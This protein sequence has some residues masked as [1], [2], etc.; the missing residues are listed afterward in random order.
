[1]YSLSTYN[2]NRFYEAAKLKVDPMSDKYPSM[3]PYVY[4]SNNPIRRIDPNGMLDG[5]FFDWYGKYLGTDGNKK[6][7]KVFIVSDNK[8]RQQIKGNER[9]G[10]T[11]DASKVKADV[12]TTKEV[13]NETLNVYGRTVKNGGDDEE[14]STFDKNGKLK[15][16]PTGNKN[17]SAIDESGD[18]SIH[19]HP[20]N[21][22]ENGNLYTTEEGEDDPEAFSGYNLNI[23]VGDS[24]CDPEGVGCN[25]TPEATFYDSKTEIIGTMKLSD[26]KKITDR[27]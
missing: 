22:L 25:R 1:M 3:S 8:S 16:Y 26:I 7:N 20:L 9:R 4:C 2:N 12:S 21:I 10:K 15:T 24:N 17:K 6:D 13:L 5:D 14:A 27:K 11:T 23:I 18:V 19:S